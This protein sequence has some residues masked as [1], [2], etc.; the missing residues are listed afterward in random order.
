MNCAR[1]ALQA[2]VKD[3]QPEM[4]RLLS[5]A[6]QIPSI[7]GD[8]RAITDFYTDRLSSWGWPVRKRLLTAEDGIPSSELADGRACIVVELGNKSAPRVVLNGHVDVV[9][10]GDRTDWRDDP[11]SG[12]KDGGQVFGRGTVDMKG[13]IAA[14]LWALKALDKAGITL[15]V[16][17]CFQ[18]VVGEETTGVGTRVL[19]DD[20]AESPIRGAIIL[21][22]TQNRIVRVN[23]GLQ[24]FTVDVEGQ[25]THTSAPWRGVDAFE[26]ML[27]VLEAMKSVSHSRGE[28]FTHAD[29]A[30]LPTALPFAIGTVRAGGYRASIPASATMSGRYGLAPGEDPAAV[31]EIY[32]DATTAVAESDSWLSEHPPQVRWDNEGLVGWETPE[33]SPLIQALSSSC[34]QVLGEAETVGFTA[35]SDAA[36]FGQRGVETTVFGPGDITLA[37]APN[38]AIDISRVADAALVVAMTLEKL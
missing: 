17:V 6:V 29:F 31:R 22:P 23:T 14:G 27:I 34:E 24:F 15:D 3:L 32:L 26:K 5:E 7:T 13:G 28:N 16:Q 4:V 38:E 2:A 1:S 20:L 19:L 18:L 25:P 21:E 36:A 30:E 11:F 10:A 8:E 35:G 33:D 12:R 9:P 37:H